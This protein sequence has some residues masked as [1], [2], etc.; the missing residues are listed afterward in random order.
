[1]YA[2]CLIAIVTVFA[3]VTAGAREEDHLAPADGY[4]SSY[5]LACLSYGGP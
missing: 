5:G 1:M 4:L 2:R 3:A